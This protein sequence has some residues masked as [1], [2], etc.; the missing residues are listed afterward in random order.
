MFRIIMNGSGESGFSPVTEPVTSPAFPPGRPASAVLENYY[1]NK[2]IL[3]L[4]L[5]FRK[6]L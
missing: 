6:T 3:A 4:V 5:N 1:L 2:Y